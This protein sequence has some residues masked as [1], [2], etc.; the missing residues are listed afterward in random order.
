MHIP[1]AVL[2]A[3]LTMLSNALAV[4]LQRKAA[5]RVPLHEGLGRGLMAGL[6]RQRVWLGGMLAVL[7]AACFQALALGN[8]PLSVVQPIFVLEL[9]AALLLGSVILRR[10]LPPDAWRAAGFVTVGLGVAL[11]AASPTPGDTQ[12]PMTRWLVALAC[13]LGSAA[14][15][16]VSAAR[17]RPGPARAAALALAAAL[18]YA[19]TAALLKSAAQTWET[20]GAAGFFTAW[21]TYGF[22]AVGVTA[23]FLLQHAL[24]SGPLTF[25]QPALILGDAGTSVALG[26]LLY[27][28]QLR[29]GWWVVPEV[30]GLMLIMAGIVLLSR[31]SAARNLIGPEGSAERA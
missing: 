25:S 19:L 5:Q 11:G 28:E 3:L 14:A 31:S 7:A 21:Q 9:P 13:C 2:F 27:D 22:A 8:G 4:V 20:D 16:T 6:V 26:V 30:I 17:R 29:G 10:G 12:A 23:L 18:C 1:L 24:Q 15:L